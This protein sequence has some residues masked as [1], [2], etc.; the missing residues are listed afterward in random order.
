VVA[1]LV[2]GVGLSFA[3]CCE[4]RKVS[5]VFKGCVDDPVLTKSFCARLEEKREKKSS[6]KRDKKTDTYTCSLLSVPSATNVHWHMGN[7]AEATDKL[8]LLQ[9]RG[10]VACP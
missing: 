8:L 7:T 5:E 1:G 9:D 10:L 2:P 6:E 3:G 4:D